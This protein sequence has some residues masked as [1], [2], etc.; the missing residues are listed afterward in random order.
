MR[1]RLNTVAP[2]LE[3]AVLAMTP[4]RRRSTA[5]SAVRWALDLVQ[6]SHP[7]IE[8]A[9]ASGQAEG[10]G[11][12]VQE[13]DE[14]YFLLQETR[15]S[16]RASER[17]VLRAFALARTVSALEFATRD[18]PL[19]AI[20]EAGIATDNWPALRNVILRGDA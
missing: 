7:V 6:L 16:G 19:E 9:L 3:A 4:D 20:Y 13:L 15:D 14:Q 8:K 11:S 17:E 5:L 10:L 18:E 1:S 12:F 2:D